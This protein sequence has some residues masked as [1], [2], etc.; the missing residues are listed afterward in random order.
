[1]RSNWLGLSLCLGH[2]FHASLFTSFKGPICS[3]F[4]IPS[5]L[6]RSGPVRKIMYLRSRPLASGSVLSLVYLD[7]FCKTLSLFT[8]ASIFEPKQLAATFTNTSNFHCWNSQKGSVPS[9]LALH[10]AWL[11]GHLAMHMLKGSERFGC[12]LDRQCQEKWSNQLLQRGTL[13]KSSLGGWRISAAP[14]AAELPE[15]DFGHIQRL[16]LIG[17]L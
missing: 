16:C 1:M 11:L 10:C 7:I 8:I 17:T 9:C 6:F 12:N 13:T 2:C 4:S 5:L 14:D 15:P 3:Y